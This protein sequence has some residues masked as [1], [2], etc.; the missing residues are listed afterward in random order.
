MSALNLETFF[1]G[2]A[3][4]VSSFFC[5]AQNC[6]VGENT[7][8]GKTPV[9]ASVATKPIATSSPV[10]RSPDKSAATAALSPP[11]KEE[12][13]PTEP[14]KKVSKFKADMQRRLQQ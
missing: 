12:T 6:S 13:A 4:A 1:G 7:G 10:D 3:G 11:K 9:Q 8:L 14:P 2:S 5:R